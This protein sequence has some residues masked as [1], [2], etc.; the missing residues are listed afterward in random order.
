MWILSKFGVFHAMALSFP[1]IS[2]VF[3][4]IAGFW[5]L[6]GFPYTNGLLGILA[7][8]HKPG[9]RLPNTDV[10]MKTKYTGIGP[11]D[12]QLTSLVAFFYTAT[13]GNRPD[14]SLLGLDL[15]G[16]VIAAWVLMVLES[17]RKSNHGMLLT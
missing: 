15:G 8:L 12:G 5:T 1:K 4:S 3:L 2:L 7:D 6:W 16:Q 11:I 14:V 13:D 10:P 9:A 17:L